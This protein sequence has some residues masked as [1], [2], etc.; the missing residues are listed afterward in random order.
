MKNRTKLICFIIAAGLMVVLMSIQP[1]TAAETSEAKG[2]AKESSDKQSA[3]EL[4]RQLN[5]PVSNIWSLTF[6]YNHSLLKGFPADGTEDQDVLN[7]QPALPLHMTE[8]WNLIL[9][10]VVPFIFNH[11]VLSPRIDPN[12]DEIYADFND[13]S[14]LGDIALVTLLSPAKLDSRFLWGIGPTF[15]FP[16]ASKDELGQEKW[17]AGPSA[18]GLW[19]GKE[20]ILGVFPQH[21]WSFAGNGDRSSTS[22]TN[23]Q[24]FIWRMLPGE[25]QIGMSPNITM[26]WKAE[27]N[28]NRFTVPVGLGVGK[29]VKLGKLPVKIQLQGQY[30]VIHPHDYGQRWNFQLQVTPVI[31]NLISDVLFK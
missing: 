1:S 23:I 15:I 26:N 11:P 3:Q 22:F 7:F 21:W 13:E 10:P 20:W 19:M 16:T 31:P 6:Q 27:K 29:L 5:N 12:T 30:S 24:Y 17:Q 28:D 2:G 8:K 18:V 25:W 9:R 4:A 14:G